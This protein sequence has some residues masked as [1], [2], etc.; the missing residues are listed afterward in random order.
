MRD[1]EKGYME[2]TCS[3]TVAQSQN[4]Q[5]TVF[6]D[7]HPMTDRTKQCNKPDT[8]LR[9]RKGTCL[10]IDVSIPSDKNVKKGETA[11]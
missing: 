8:K 4:N 5:V 3:Q 1:G 7:Q 10:L 9:D 6:W 2:G 11:K